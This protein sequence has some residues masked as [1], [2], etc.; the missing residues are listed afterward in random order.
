MPFY[1][2][3]RPYLY[4]TNFLMPF[5]RKYYFY[6][7]YTKESLQILPEL[8]TPIVHQPAWLATPA[9]HRLAGLGT[10]TVQLPAL[11]TAPSVNVLHPEF[12]LKIN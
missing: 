9:V 3:M 2:A 11:L 12:M 10:P 8:A 1:F 5:L 6:L 7:I 4:V